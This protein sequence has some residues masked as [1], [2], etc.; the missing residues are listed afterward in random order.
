MK[1]VF[2]TRSLTVGGAER[3]LVTLAKGL[4][5]AGHAVSIIVYYAGGELEG[6]ASMAMVPVRSPGKRG[7]WDL[8]GFG[9]RLTALLRHERPDVLFSFLPVSNILAILTRMFIPRT[10]VAWGIRS[11]DDSLNYRG[12]IDRFV[13]FFE[14]K[15]SCFADIIIANSRSGKKFALARGFPRERCAVVPNG[16]NV[17][18]FFPDPKGRAKVRLELDLDEG[19]ILL[20]LVDRLD[21]VKDLVNLI[22][23]AAMMTLIHPEFRFLCVCDGSLKLKNALKQMAKEALSERKLIWLD[24]RHDM[25]EIYNAM[26]ILVSAS[27]N[28]GFSMPSRKPWPVANPV[29]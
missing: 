19:V 6:E 28:E 27:Y 5:E 7:R 1:I 17:H 14:S 16:I 3:Q 10:K 22:Q 23:A 15:L 25:P 18:R 11:S 13:G 29:L 4:K 9:I 2:L 12:K 24:T 20:C 8:M 21:P 26:D